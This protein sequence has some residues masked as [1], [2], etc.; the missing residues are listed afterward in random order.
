MLSRIVRLR[1][2]FLSN[3]VKLHKSTLLD[4]RTLQNTS[5]ATETTAVL[6]GRMRIPLVKWWKA[7]ETLHVKQRINSTKTINSSLPFSEKK[8]DCC[9]GIFDTRAGV[10][11]RDAGT[12]QACWDFSEI[13]HY[14]AAFHIYLLKIEQLLCFWYALID[15]YHH[16]KVM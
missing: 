15:S 6:N 5:G 10:L 4:Q 16:E 14:V 9:N 3:S 13:E 12:G 8:N 7:T 2:R 1:G 11:Q